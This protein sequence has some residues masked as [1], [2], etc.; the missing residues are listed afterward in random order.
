MKNL[1]IT[2]LATSTIALNAW[3]DHPDSVNNTDA[4]FNNAQEQTG[5]GNQGNG[6]Y[7]SDPAS[8]DTNSS[9]KSYDEKW[10]FGIPD[11]DK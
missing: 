9:G 11:R 3:D 4:A 6:S 10:W 7:Y 5:A 2:L 8:K 1:I